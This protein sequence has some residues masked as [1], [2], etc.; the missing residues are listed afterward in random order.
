MKLKCRRNEESRQL[1]TGGVWDLGSRT[2]PDTV[3]FRSTQRGVLQA[4][5]GGAVG[6][7]AREGVQADGVAED[8][9]SK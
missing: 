3:T 2:R 9:G 5:H 4:D 8:Q 6:D 1:Q 7:Q